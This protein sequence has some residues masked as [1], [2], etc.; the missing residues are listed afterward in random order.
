MAGLLCDLGLHRVDPAIVLNG[1]VGFSRCLRCGQALVRRPGSRWGLVPRGHAVVWRPVSAGRVGRERWSP[2]RGADHCVHHPAPIQPAM[3]RSSVASRPHASRAYRYLARQIA[4]ARTDSGAAMIVLISA[5]CSPA[6]SNETLMMLCAM[7]H[8]E[9]GGRL[10]VIDATLTQEGI[11]AALGADGR[12]GL[13]EARAA[14]PWDVLEMLHLPTRRAL[15]VLG[16]GYRPGAARPEDMVGILPFLA[17]R[18]DHILIQQQAITADTRYLAMAARADLVLVLAEEGGTRM[19][20]L[21]Q[22]R[23][24]FRTHGIAN[25][26]MVLAVPSAGTAQARARAA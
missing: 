23:D 26:G 19:A 8:D 9:L 7:M 10:L 5:V 4:D 16:A 13:S 24:A 25:V 2:D 21:A 6:L 20:R 14:H 18:F 3:G 17:Q 15:F 12:P 22:A 11:G 1:G